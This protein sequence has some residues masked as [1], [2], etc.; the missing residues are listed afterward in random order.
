MSG[1]TDHLHSQRDG[2]VASDP[3]GRKPAPDPPA[4]DRSGPETS[5]LYIVGIGASAGGLESLERFFANVPTDSG[6]AFVVI[7]HLSPDFKSLM[8]E[9]L[10]RYTELPIHRAEDGMMVEA[11]SIYLIPPKKEMIISR[12]RLLL[13]DKDPKQSLAMPIDLFFRSLAQDAGDRAMGVILS[14]TGSD[15]SRAIRDIHDVGGIVICESRES[16]KFDGMPQSAIDTGVVD[17]ILPPESMPAS[18]IRHA[19]QQPIIAEIDGQSPLPDAMRELFRLLNEQCGIDFSHYKPNTVGRRIQRRITMLGLNNLREYVDRLRIDPAELNA[20]YKDLLIGVTRFFRDPEAFAMLRDLV[21]SDLVARATEKEQIRIW[22]AGCA[23]GEEAYSVAMLMHEEFESLGCSPNVKIFATDAHRASLDIAAAGVYSEEA[24][25]DVS[26]QRLARYF[27][28]KRD[29]F[30]VVPELR[31]M[32]VFA[33][34]N[35]INDAPFTKLDLITCRNLLIYFDPAAQKKSLSL[36]H[37]G[38][39]T[40]GYLFLGTSESPGELQE[41]FESIDLHWKIFRKSRD[42]RLATDLRTPLIGYTGAPARPLV[43]SPPAKRLPDASLVGAYDAILKKFMPPA[44]LINERREL[45]H[46][47][48]GAE[49]FLHPKGGRPTSDVL[50]LLD[51]ELRTAVTGAVQR[52]LKENAPIYYSG[53]HINTDRGEEQLRVTI[54]P[55]ENSRSRYKQL[56][57]VIEPISTPA[58]AGQDGDSSGESDMQQMSRDRIESLEQELRYNK[59]N[60]QTTVEE[61]ETSNEELQASNEELVTSN[62]ELQSTNEELQSVNEELFSVNAEYQKKIAELAEMTADIENLL[63]STEVGTIFLD[64]ELCIRKYT[65]QIAEQFH[66]L[67]QDVGRSIA[68]FAHSFDYPQLLAD[69]E[70]VLANNQRRELEVQDR[71]GRWYYLRILPYTTKAKMDG[72]VLTLFD[73]STVKQVQAELAQAVRR[74]DQFL[75]MLSHELRNPLGAILNAAN[76]MERCP[77]DV[78]LVTELGDIIRRQSQHMAR[79]LDDLLDVSRV[80]QNKIEM[81]KQPVALSTIVQGAIESVRPEI[82]QNK[83]TFEQKFSPIELAVLGD[84]VR[85]QQAVSNL[86]MNAAKYTPSGGSIRLETCEDHGQVVIRVVD[87]GTGI[88]K[89]QIQ[90]IFDLFVQSDDTLH[91]S[92]GGMGV[93]LTLVRSIIEQHDGTVTAASDGPG[94]GSCFEI[95]LPRHL[96]LPQ[97]EL[98]RAAAAAQPSTGGAVVIVEDQD[99]NRLMLKRLLEL[100]GHQVFAAENG[101]KGLAAIEQHQ[102]RI[103]LIDIGLPGLDGYQVAKHI[104]ENFGN[105]SVYL[106][107]LTGYGQPQDV[108]AALAAG[109]DT[110]LVKPLDPQR[111]RSLMAARASKR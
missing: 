10:A 27:D 51:H 78:D 8:D 7:Q 50:D 45:L 54:E 49:R 4:S 103:A 53:V 96:E 94:K 98:D 14:G 3:H 19:R 12:G 40:G 60:L 37:F 79:L 85:L 107:A 109:F 63:A 110:H 43:L 38:L 84:P 73:I 99:D 105:N 36:F 72:V 55:L 108:Q 77:K 15:G 25:A 35:L 111:L 81:R 47:F 39:K 31:K 13:T 1:K 59:E 80:T 101:P 29:G 86:L 56:L 75:A 62:E 65:P 48:G 64:R 102:P 18:L 67:P 28:R 57:I 46:A 70:Q 90:S 58:H 104:R 21:I 92:K 32:I 89:E 24:L 95:R 26:R 88:S 61:L 17:E 93:G 82:D 74:R 22:I 42:V 83:L 6:L 91:R 5:R 2:H 16:A 11:D 71:Q 33:A 106:V 76:I 44:I 34:H 100:D 23:T 87:N 52:A 20:L 97:S 30:H 66:L 41:E 68:S 69:L 9:L